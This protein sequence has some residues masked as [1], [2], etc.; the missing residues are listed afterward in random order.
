LNSPLTLVVGLKSTMYPCTGQL[1]IADHHPNCDVLTFR[2]SGHTPL[3][4]QP[5]RFFQTLKGFAQA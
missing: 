2:N 1:R 4:D 5:Y 3:I